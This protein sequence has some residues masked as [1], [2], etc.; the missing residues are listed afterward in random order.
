VSGRKKMVPAYIVQRIHWEYND[1]YYGRYEGEAVKTFLDRAKAEAYRREREHA[2]RR[3]WREGPPCEL[4][5]G[6]LD[7]AAQTSLSPRQLTDRLAELGM[8]D[9]GMQE[10][11][12]WWDDL[13]PGERDAV[14]DLFDKVHFFEVRP[15]RL[16][17]EG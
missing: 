8:P 6:G 16:E 4:N 1:E 10:T 17:V 14:W 9:G 12:D 3:Q 7:T 11:S 13:D 15:V 5:M 2:A